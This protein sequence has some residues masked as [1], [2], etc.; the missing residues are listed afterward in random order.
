MTDHSFKFLR[1]PG[2][3]LAAAVSMVHATDPPPAAQPGPMH[4]HG[5]PIQAARVESPEECTYCGMNRTRFARSR[6]LV[7]Y[8][9]GSQVGTCSIHCTAI[10]L[11]KTQGNAPKALRVGDRAD[12]TN[13]LIDAR[14]AFWV[15]GGS[16][17]GVMTPLPK[18]AFATKA[19]AEAF[20][21]KLGGKQASFEEALAAATQELKK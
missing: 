17:R 2:L 18:W 9:D 16:E 12:A 8:A 5:A 3:A 11:R 7:E 21:Q 15:I 13:K 4:Q 1:I 14:T 6:M 10:E 19:D 20:I